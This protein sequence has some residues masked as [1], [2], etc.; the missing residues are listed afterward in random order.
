MCR[1][2]RW[3]R[4]ELGPEDQETKKGGKETQARKVSGWLHVPQVPL[5]APVQLSLS[6]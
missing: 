2:K 6:S 4:T 1:K 5:S 3:L